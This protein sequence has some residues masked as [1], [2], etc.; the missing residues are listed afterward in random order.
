MRLEGVET[1]KAFTHD[2]ISCIIGWP[3]SSRFSTPGFAISFTRTLG[4]A[5]CM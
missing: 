5:G 1:K 3:E 4:Y 2:Y